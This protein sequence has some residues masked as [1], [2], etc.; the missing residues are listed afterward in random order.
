M[1]NRSE[2]DVVKVS[3]GVGSLE[4]V[5]WAFEKEGK[6]EVVLEVR[7]GDGGEAGRANSL[8]GK[9]CVKIEALFCG[10]DGVF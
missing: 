6:R 5:W 10:R 2:E 8:V 7:V 1:R 9:E 3:K 4:N